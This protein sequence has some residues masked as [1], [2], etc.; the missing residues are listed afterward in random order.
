LSR[1][2]VVAPTLDPR[3]PFEPFT[4]ANCELLRGDEVGLALTP[5]L[6]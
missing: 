5:R 2:Q 6:L 1:P 4:F 3:E